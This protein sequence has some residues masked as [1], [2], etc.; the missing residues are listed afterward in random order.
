MA[1]SG[2]AA[3]ERCAPVS[4]AFAKATRHQDPVGSQAAMKV[5]ANALLTGVV[6][7]LYEGVTLGEKAGRSRPRSAPC[8]PAPRP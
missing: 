5:A 6:Q 8:P 3:V 7:V 2:H 4:A 1:G